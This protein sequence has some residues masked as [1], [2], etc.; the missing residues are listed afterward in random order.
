[1]VERALYDP[2]DGF[3]GGGSGAGRRADFLTSPEVGPLFS[4]VIA[5]ALDGW[6][7]ELGQPDPFTVVEVAAGTGALA[8]GVLAAAP[9]CLGALT[10][11]LVER[12]EALRDR[13][14]ERLPIGD[15]A[16]AYPP[17]AAEDVDSP[18]AEGGLGP[19]VVSLG[20]MPTLPVTGVVLA[21]EL[22]DNL[23]FRV[24]ERAE[25]GWS[26]VRVGLTGD[27]LPL[28]ELLVPADDA[29]AR[30][31]DRLAPDAVVGARVPLQRAAA[32]WLGR[33]LA[34]IERGRVVVLDYGA[35]TAD[36][37]HRP[38]EEWI[39]TY[40]AHGRGGS[41]LED[42]GR[43][44]ITCE[45]A[46]DQLALVRPPAAHR[47]QAE[48]LAAHGIDDLVAEGRRIWAERAHLGDLAAIRARSRIGEAE[49]LTDPTGLGAFHV[50]EWPVP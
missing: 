16:L 29:D 21:N 8:Q 44:D 2:V 20:E 35:T 18:S 27:E 38:P 13:Q 30:L 28:V 5:R 1:V 48:F 19:R 45:V 33:A 41:P 4:A 50:L 22:L 6:W 26:E 10:Y 25:Q 17:S 9:D 39:R 11:V 47:S 43:Q 49:A 46:L 36:L 37:A 7:T 32:D 31:A 23:V 12:S 3:F 42:L 14:R 24:L 15:A 40:R 34:L